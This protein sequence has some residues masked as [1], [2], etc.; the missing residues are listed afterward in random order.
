MMNEIERWS[1]TNEIIA[2]GLRYASAIDDRDISRF[3]SCFTTDAEWRSDVHSS[4]GHEEIGGVVRR[5]AETLDCTHHFATNFEVELDND[6]ASMRSN[7]HATHVRAPMENYVMG[8]TYHDSLIRTTEGWKIRERVLTILWTTGDAS[9]CADVVSP[10]RL[11][12]RS[13]A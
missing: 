1:A 3:I 11:E 5:A 6:T 8:G 12:S 2:L 4:R 13:H 7:F 10:R 9:M